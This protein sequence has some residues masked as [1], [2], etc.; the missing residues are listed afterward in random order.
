MLA[1]AK[2]DTEANGQEEPN[3]WKSASAS[4]MLGDPDSLLL[5]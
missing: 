1:M 5:R 2:Q 4:A 3:N